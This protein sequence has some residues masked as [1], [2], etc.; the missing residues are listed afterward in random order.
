MFWKATGHMLECVGT[1]RYVQIG[2]WKH[3]SRRHWDDTTLAQF[4]KVAL[5]AGL[6]ARDSVSLLRQI[7]FRKR[8]CRREKAARARESAWFAFFL[9]QT[10]RLLERERTRAR[11]LSLCL[12]TLKAH[13][14]QA[15]LLGIG[16]GMVIGPLF[17]HLDL[18]P[19]ATTAAF[20]KSLSLS[21]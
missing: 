13:T 7:V 15:G 10:W 2:H 21:G 9:S 8:V 11:S 19:Q 18:Q 4:P 6:A 12:R 16:G 14:R 20:R 3:E 1:L 5:L 17:M